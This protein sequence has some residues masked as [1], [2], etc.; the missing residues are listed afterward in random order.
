VLRQLQQAWIIAAEALSP[1]VQLMQQPSFVNSHLQM[2]TV[3]LHWQHG[4][5]LHV[6][7][8]LHMPSASMRQR[9]C[10]V[11]RETSS[12]Q[13]QWILQPVA[14]FSNSTLQR[15]STHQ[16]ALTGEP[17]GMVPGCTP[18]VGPQY[19]AT[20][21]DPRSNRVEDDITQTPS[22]WPID[23]QLRWEATSAR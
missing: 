15:G 1:E 7:Q 6:Q 9:F 12:S 14:V 16:F 18:T 20:A 8:Q 2:P 10:S 21:E 11:P 13:R 5:P 19:G 17:A 23:E 3:K 22:K 4:M